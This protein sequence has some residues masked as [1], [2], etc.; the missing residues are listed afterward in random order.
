[1]GLCSS[2]IH[3]SVVPREVG[4]RRPP[5]YSVCMTTLPRADTEMNIVVPN[6]ENTMV[7]CIVEAL[8]CSTYTYNQLLSKI[9]KVL[10]NPRISEYAETW[11]VINDTFYES[12]TIG[13][14]M[15]VIKDYLEFAQI[16]SKKTSLGLDI[17]I[18]IDRNRRR[19]F[20]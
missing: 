15:R 18:L 3:Q 5:S 16:E 17:V 7:R 14:I 1:M 10:N 19:A 8:S 20:S 9:N 11:C 12:E 6:E 4:R 13:D 2:K